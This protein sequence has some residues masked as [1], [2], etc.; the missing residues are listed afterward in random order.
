MVD[1]DGNFEALI[2]LFL[3]AGVDGFWPLEVASG[4]DPVIL[5]K[6]YGKS[7]S[8][9]GGVDKRVIAAGKKEIN[10]ELKRLTPVIEEGG[11]IPTLDHAAPPD[12]P[13]QNFMYYLDLK[14]KI[15]FG[16]Y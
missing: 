10:I 11:F 3:E 13:F 9:S 7:F 5:R 16:N 15:I 8:I 6:K 12:I 1:T 2:P 4:M 14:R